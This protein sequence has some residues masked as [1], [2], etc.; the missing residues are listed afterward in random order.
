MSYRCHPNTEG[1]F[2]TFV[3]LDS[4]TGTVNFS[5]RNNS[6]G[7]SFRL[8]LATTNLITEAEQ[9]FNKLEDATPRIADEIRE[10]DFKE[11]VAKSKREQGQFEQFA[12]DERQAFLG[13]ARG[14]FAIGR[15]FAT[16]IPTVQKNLVRAHVWLSLAAAQGNNEAA[17]CRDKIIHN[18]TAEQIDE[19]QTLATT[20]KPMTPEEFEKHNEEIIERLRETVGP[21][22][23]T[24]HAPIA[25]DRHD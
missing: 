15:M 13:D 21:V 22:V 14:Q 9:L 6:T 10:R 4:E 20:W 25:R 19:A 2:E 16:G 18:M 12:E 7:W 11:L 8:I 1:M 3:D 5:E 24:S 23:V 17:I